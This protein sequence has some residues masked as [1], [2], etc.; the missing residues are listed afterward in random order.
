ERVNDDTM[1]LVA[2]KLAALEATDSQF[3]P[4]KE[5]EPAMLV[6]CFCSCVISV[7]TFALSTP[8][9][10]AA[11]SLLLMELTTSMALFMAVYAVSVMLAPRPS[12]SCTVDRACLSDF[13]VVAIDQ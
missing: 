3:W 1:D 9:S 5:A 12:A 8:G 7:C 10:R 2:W 4:E 6:S 13:M 11:T